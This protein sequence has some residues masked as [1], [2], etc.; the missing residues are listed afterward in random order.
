MTTFKTALNKQ[1]RAVDSSHVVHLFW[2]PDPETLYVLFKRGC[3]YA[4]DGVPASTYEDLCNAPSVGVTLNGL[5][6]PHYRSRML[7]VDDTQTL[8]ACLLSAPHKPNVSNE[9]VIQKCNEL[10]KSAAT[11]A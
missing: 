4:Y 3:A 8:H 6:K 10:Q 2:H 11:S 5:V 9:G 7:S 1:H